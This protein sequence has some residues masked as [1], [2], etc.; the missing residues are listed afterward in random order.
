[1]RRRLLVLA[2]LLAAGCGS[3]PPAPVIERSQQPQ[4]AVFDRRIV[5]DGGRYRVRAGDTLYGIAFTLALDFRDVAAWNGI[6]SPYT[7]FPGQVL[8]LVPPRPA[9]NSPSANAERTQPPA[10]T[11]VPKPAAGKEANGQA[12]R[13]A[14]SSPAPASRPAS[15]GADPQQWI[16]P[17]KGKI[18][19]GYSPTDPAR[20]GLDIAGREG[21]PVLAA[22]PGTVVYSG[23]GLIGYGELVIIKHS[24][25]MLS[26]YGH[27]R[28]R[29][30]DEGAQIRAGQKIAE[31]GR[32]DRNEVVLHFEIRVNGRPVNPLG[33]LPKP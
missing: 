28:V 16:W 27:N 4:A 6:R 9:A 25:R 31:V 20:D 32:N 2:V 29:L 1:L 21:Q 24:E 22:A 5:L 7:I 23:N 3:K 12:G 15:T 18:V 13:A 30:V 19:R 17:V 14:Q 26:A 33:Y 10:N 8:Q 11:T